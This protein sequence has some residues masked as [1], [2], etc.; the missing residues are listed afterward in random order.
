[1]QLIFD[2]PVHPRYSFENFVVCGGNDVAFRFA[3]MLASDPCNQVLYIYGPAGCGKT[4][5]LSALG[6]RLMSPLYTSDAAETQIPYIS[7]KDIDELYKGNYIAEQSSVL[8]ERFQ[9]SPILLI[10]DLHLIPD[11][12]NIRIEVWQIFNDF[13]NSGRKIAV[14]GLHHPR[15]LPT[16]DDHLISRLLCG[17]AAGMDVSDDDSRRLI[18]KKLADDRQITI[19]A[20][21]IDHLLLHIRRDIPS[22]IKGLDALNHQALSS[23]RKISLR[24]ARKVLEGTVDI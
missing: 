6:K 11:N 8:A 7:F 9:N 19:S 10:D 12:I 4:H 22:L 2:F 15:Q 13:F 17:L 14:T 1:M 16:L 18:M 3:G 21:V 20:E 24:L 23:G 5:L